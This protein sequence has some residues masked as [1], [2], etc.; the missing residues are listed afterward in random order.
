MSLNL[1]INPYAT[2]NA[3]GSFSAASGGY[4]AGTAQ[5]GP[6][7]RYKLAGGVLNSTETLPMFGGV[8]VYEQVN[9]PAYS[10]TYPSHDLGNLIGRATTV[11]QTSS[12]GIAG[13]SVFDQ[14]DSAINS[15]NNP[16]PLI[17]TGGQ[18]NFYRLG[19]G[20]K[21]VVAAD[22]GLVSLENGSISAN[23][24]WDWNNQI[25]VPYSASTASVSVTSLTWA[26]TNGGQIAVVAAA[27]T[28]V[29]AVGDEVWISG[30][31]NTG[32]L[33]NTAVNGSFTV[34]TFTD[35]QHFT[36]TATGT[37]AQYGTIA[38]TITIAQGTGILPVKVL[39]LNIG[40]S[41]VPSYSQVTGNYTWNRSGSAALILI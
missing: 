19:S 22:P 15:P 12:T 32:S 2:G 29:Q 4:V 24:S 33:G 38:G 28:T 9:N 5:V 14:N 20:A 27:A 21:I 31:T 40:N 41:M 23:V 1:T 37:S 30:A 25:L 8:A 36:V 10:T 18:V 11:T 34:N 35:N 26:A 17:G 7:T 3:A 6:E 13:F 16:V 39:D